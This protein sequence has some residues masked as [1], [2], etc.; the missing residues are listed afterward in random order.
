MVFLSQQPELGQELK[1]LKLGLCF[2]LF[3]SG[4][5]SDFQ[6]M[7]TQEG[8]KNLRVGKSHLILEALLQYPQQ[9]T[10][11]SLNTPDAV[12]GSLPHQGIQSHHQVALVTGNTFLIS[13]EI[14]IPVSPTH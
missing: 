10:V 14:S 13:P 9:E 2:L 6:H 11:I 1:E 8:L 12:L 5:F 3:F 4:S 7:G